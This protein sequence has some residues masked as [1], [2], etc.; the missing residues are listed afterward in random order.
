MKKNRN[1]NITIVFFYIYNIINHITEI[2]KHVTETTGQN[3][4]NNLNAQCSGRITQK[5]IPRH[6]IVKE[7]VVCKKLRTIWDLNEQIFKNN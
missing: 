5:L 3:V 4:K 2:L 6:F 1:K 7:C